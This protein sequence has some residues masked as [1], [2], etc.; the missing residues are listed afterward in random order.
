MTLQQ[1]LTF[2]I[3]ADALTSTTKDSDRLSYHARFVA[4]DLRDAEGQL[5]TS[6]ASAELTRRLNKGPERGIRG[7]YVTTTDPGNSGG[8]VPSTTPSLFG[9]SDIGVVF[10]ER[11][12]IRPQG[13][14]LGEHLISLSLGPSE[15]VTIEQKTY[16]ERQN[17]FEEATEQDDTRE[18]EFSSSLSTEL[19]NALQRATNETRTDQSNMNV[20]GGGSLYGVS[21]SVSAGTSNSI[22]SGDTAS[23]NDTT[24]NTK[25]KSE[26][27]SS[28]YRAQ[29]KIM[30]R[31]SETSKFESSQKRVIRNPNPYTPV[32]LVYFKI[33][34][35][36]KLSHER[37]GVRFCWAPFVKDPGAVVDGAFSRQ[38]ELLAQ[39]FPPAPTLP[40]PPMPIPAGA[41]P[42]TSVMLGLTELTNWGLPGDMSANYTYDI[43]T[44]EGYEWDSDVEYIKQNLTY[45]KVGKWGARGEPD[46]HIDAAD[47]NSSGGV[48]VVVHAGVNGGG[49]GAKLFTN[50]SVRFRP[51]TA[52]PDPEYAVKLDKW[53]QDKAD[54]QN[55][56]EVKEAER[57]AKIETEL[58]RWAVEFWKKFDPVS[59]SMQLLVSFL[60]PSSYDEG[61]EVELWNQLFDFDGSQI[62]LYPSWWSDRP[63]RDPAVGPSAFQNAS[64][65]RVFLPIRLGFEE[66]A[67]R[68]LL[69]RQTAAGG[70]GSPVEIRIKELVDEIQNFRTKNFGGLEEITVGSPT[71]TPPC[72][73][74]ENPYICLGYWEELLPTDGTHLEVVQAITSAA[75][76]LSQGRLDRQVSEQKALIDSAISETALKTALAKSNPSPTSVVV[77]ISQP[78]SDKSD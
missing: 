16:S 60:P 18:S 28:K 65:A 36:L 24:K 33:L 57:Q 27:I 75:D 62:M 22:A 70:T 45:S 47:H 42:V 77:N 71:G 67:L 78:P 48:R 1:R 4:I 31:I 40:E 2:A 15:E 43:D 19:S 53:R 58:Q 66:L 25:T 34:Q 12:R 72:P 61:N 23:R 26:K 74:V 76:D 32:D 59:A 39:Q 21:L 56:K 44:P 69:T 29:H 6:M 73:M 5:L 52:G 54:W 49:G 38:R 37:Y 20:G 10:L 11:T 9:D 7:L 64:W 35:R 46:V 68:W 50:F 41:P 30:F 63:L 8:S 55:Q 51:I 3:A 17:T 13:F 14:A